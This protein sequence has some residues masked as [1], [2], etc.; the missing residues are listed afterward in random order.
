MT[1][2]LSKDRFEQVVAQGKDVVLSRCVQLVLEMAENIRDHLSRRQSHGKPAFQHETVMS[3]MGEAM[4]KVSLALAQG[5]ET[6]AYA[7]TE[8]TKAAA[9]L[10]KLMG[11]HGYVT[12]ALAD[13][14]YWVRMLGLWANEVQP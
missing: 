1:E 10:S 5:P 4:A 13:K 2:E 6:Q 11:G 12:G 14:E 8:L 7:H 9:Q 3:E